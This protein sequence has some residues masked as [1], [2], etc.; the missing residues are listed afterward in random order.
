MRAIAVLPVVFFHFEIAGFTGGYLGVDIF[1][2]ISGFLI[3]SIIDRE[4]LSGSFS[5]VNFYERRIRRILPA[6]LFITGITTGVCWMVFDPNAFSNFGLSLLATTVFSSNIYFWTE[7]GYFSAPALE[8]PLLHTWSLSIEEQF[9]IFFP[10]LLLALHAVYKKGK[11]TILVVFWI[12]SFLLCIYGDHR[13]PDA[14]FYLLPTRAWELL[15]GALLAINLFPKVNSNLISNCLSIIGILMVL[16]GIFFIGS[17]KPSHVHYGIFPVVGCMMVIYGNTYSGTWVGKVLSKPVFVKIGLISYSLYLWHWPIDVLAR[18]LAIRPLGNLDKALLLLLSFAL[19]YGTWKFIE[20]PF[21]LKGKFFVRK[22]ALFGATAFTMVL[23]SA[24]GA[25]IYYQDGMA[26]RNPNG[27]DILAQANWEWHT[28]GNQ[29]AYGNVELSPGFTKPGE[30]GVRGKAPEVALWGDSHAIAWIPGLH[31]SAKASGKTVAILTRSSC[32]PILGYNQFLPTLD[33]NAITR[34]VIKYIQ[35]EDRIQT[36]ILTAAWHDYFH[37]FRMAGDP[38]GALTFARARDGLVAVVN[39]M[40]ELG[41]DVIILTDVPWLGTTGYG[42]TVRSFYLHSLFPDIYDVD[43]AVA[44][45]TPQGY[46]EKNRAILSFF[47]ELEADMGIRVV[48]VEKSFYDPDNR[49]LL[50]VDGI[51]IYRDPGHLSTFGSKH[52]STV[53]NGILKDGG[54]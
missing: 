54:S 52:L 51:P 17:L 5:I 48:Q 41:R 38:D 34:D 2:V 39:E 21:R 29:P 27:G 53:F 12:L 42:Y 24:T 46:F 10:I 18:Y 25:L 14:T 26:W 15:S 4:I 35:Q 13:Y 30:C 8:K 9:Y 47:R 33:T 31:K 44:S 37:K 32:P 20:Q 19:A 22:K 50:S 1:F 11:A 16:G 23:S 28:T 6:L 3:T 49:F 7:A 43:K 40:K 45:P 36:L